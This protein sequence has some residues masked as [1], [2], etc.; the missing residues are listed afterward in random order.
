MLKDHL[1]VG[2]QHLQ[3]TIQAYESLLDTRFGKIRRLAPFNIDSQLLHVEQF[4]SWRNSSHSSVL[5]LKGKTISPH[6]TYLSWLSPAAVH[7]IQNAER[8]LLDDPNDHSTVV[9]SYCCQTEDGD[10]ASEKVSLATV[11]S[12]LIY[13]LLQTKK[14]QQLLRDDDRYRRLE[15]NIV[16]AFG[17]GASPKR[18][19]QSRQLYI[20]FEDLLTTLSLRRVYLL[21]DRTDRIEG[22]LGFEHSAFLDLPEKR[23][24][25]GYNV[26]VKLFIV[27]PDLTIEMTAQDISKTSYTHIIE[28]NQGG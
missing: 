3:A 15:R 4:R 24:E 27:V 12:S 16:D 17:S 14:A 11:I 19:E 18:R 6:P 26:T 28:C 20:I 13:Q 1:K 9:I 25:K 5:I 21:I 23:L 8:H 10:G 2:S 7:L 22:T